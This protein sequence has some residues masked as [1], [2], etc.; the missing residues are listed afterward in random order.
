ML[1]KVREILRAFD[2]AQPG[3][4][5]G[6]VVG[7][8][9]A[10][11]L[12]AVNVRVFMNDNIP[13]VLIPISVLREGNVELSEFEQVLEKEPAGERYWAARSEKGLYPKYPIWTG[14]ITAPL[15]IP[16]A[17]P[18][19]GQVD[20]YAL[21]AYGR[22][23]ALA[24][25]AVFAGVLANTLRRF[26]SGRWAIFLTFS[27]IF[28]SAL[29]HHLGSH[30]T[31][32]VLPN[33]CI[34]VMLSLLVRTEM[35]RGRALVAGLLAGLAAASRLPVVFVAGLP[36]GV[37]LTRSAWQRFIPFVAAGGLIFPVLTLCY[38]WAAFG[39]PL[40]TGYAFS[41]YDV[42]TARLLEGAAG[43]L[44]SPTCGLFV[45]SP[46]LVLGVWFGIRSLRG[47]LTEDQGRLGAWILLGCVGQWLL[48]AKWWCWHGAL[49]FG[50]RMLAETVAPV[51]ILIGLG[52]PSLL[53]RSGKMVLLAG[54]AFAVV[55]HL[56]GTRAYDVV[57]RDNILKSGWD[58]FADFIALY[59]ERSGVGEALAACSLQA[60]LFLFIL[61]LGGYLASRFVLRNT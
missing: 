45:Y 48:F 6:A 25:A 42:F 53:G 51:A 2:A 37:F 17:L 23:M 43:L 19:A 29:W 30:L 59:I 46:F 33:V 11:L 54:G 47:R 38:Q 39:G 57:S 58:W 18:R 13:N 61:C 56:I 49:S 26:M 31:N 12:G 10:L 52:W 41:G 36:L 32:Q 28:G 7:V 55:H 3:L 35:T 16:F 21:L 44:I 22:L 4:R 9:A 50:C 40:K 20:E 14:V 15:F 27:V 1:S 24:L 60:A 5:F 34:V 8:W